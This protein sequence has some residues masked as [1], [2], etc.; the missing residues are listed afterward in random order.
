MQRNMYLVRQINLESDSFRIEYKHWQLF[1][2]KA[3]EAS[4]SFIP[5]D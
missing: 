2:S 3:S 4:E 1:L 5:K